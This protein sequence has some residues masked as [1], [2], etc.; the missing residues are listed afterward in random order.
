MI[1]LH[2]HLLPGVD[3]GALDDA[4]SIAMARV[5]HHD[6]I[7]AIC[8]T[9]HIRHDHDVRIG[10]LPGRVAALQ[11]ALDRHGVPVRVRPGGEVAETIVDRLSDDELRAVALGG[12]GRWVLLEPRPGPLSASLVHTTHALAARGFR[13]LVAHPERHLGADLFSCLAAA[14]EAGALVQGTAAQVEH[15]P[16]ATGMA[17]LA[18]RGLLH[19]VASDAHSSHGG[20]PVRLS[21]AARALAE[22]PAVAPHVRWMVDVAPAAIVAGRDVAAPYAATAS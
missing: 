10:E 16:A 1:D 3:D 7:A 14:V 20:R 21:G 11:A 6:G 8:A 19:V 18:R 22:I 5:A 12:G 13:A 17:E 15:G 9:P 2:C 4:D